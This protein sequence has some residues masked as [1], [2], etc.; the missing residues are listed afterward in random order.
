MNPTSDW[1]VWSEE[2]AAWWARGKLGYTDSLTEA[3]R[4]TQEEALAIVR[5]ANFYCK[6]GNWNE[7]AMPDPLAHVEQGCGLTIGR[8]YCR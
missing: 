7:C 8:N 4:Y 1:V 2:H 5:K 6:P 3:G